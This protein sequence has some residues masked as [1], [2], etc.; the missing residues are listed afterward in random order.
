MGHT[1]VI[2][3][4]GIIN[5]KR[6]VYDD[7]KEEGSYVL[8]EMC[9][10]D[11]LM[12][13]NSHIE[14]LEEGF[15]LRDYFRMIIAYDKL[16]QLDGFF[17]SYIEEYLK[18]PEDG[19][20]SDNISNLCLK[21]IVTVELHEDGHVLDIQNYINF[22]GMGNNDGI[23]WGVEFSSLNKLLDIPIKINNGTVYITKFKGDRIDKNDEFK[24]PESDSL[25]LFDFVSEIIWELSFCGTPENRDNENSKL[26]IAMEEIKDGTAKLVPWKEMENEE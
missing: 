4:N 6:W 26:N 22:D 12:E 5:K 1:L 11:I 8:T 23:N 7:V 19:C 25:K 17:P 15:T 13:S 10:D 20:I 21:R 18:C 24:S 14:T 2:K 9:P 16:Q 3:R